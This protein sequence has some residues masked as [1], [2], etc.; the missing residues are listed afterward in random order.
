[1]PAVAVVN[2]L[3]VNI[4]HLH[5]QAEGGRKADADRLMAA[6]DTVRMIDLCARRADDSQAAL[7][8]AEICGHPVID[9]LFLLVVGHAVR[10]YLTEQLRC[11]VIGLPV[12]IGKPRGVARLVS[13]GDFQRRADL[14]LPADR[15]TVL[16]AGMLLVFAFLKLLVLRHILRIF[17]A[18]VGRRAFL[19]PADLCRLRA[20]LC[21]CRRNAFF[22]Q[23]DRASRRKSERCNVQADQCDQQCCFD[24]WFHRC[25]PSVRC[26]CSAVPL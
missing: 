5:K 4:H 16:S 20:L 8:K 14:I 6:E 3:A 18:A 12:G 24:L 19:R 7:V 25:P 26:S 21:G 23:I 10:D 17:D 15:D 13:V 11:H 22:Q 2:D 1:M 9:R